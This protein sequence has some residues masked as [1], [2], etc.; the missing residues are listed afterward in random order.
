MKFATSFSI[1]LAL[2]GSIADGVAAQ[3]AQPPGAAAL[4]PSAVAES[5]VVL[6]MLDSLVLA[7]PK[8][9][10]AWHRLGM[11]AWALATRDKANSDIKQ[12]D[13]T[14]LDRMAD[15][16]LR[17]A[18]SLA[19]DSARYAL[20][21]SQFL[22][23]SGHAAAR[24]A[25][26]LMALD[27][28]A[29]GRASTNPGEHAASAM[30][31]G[32]VRWLRYESLAH[33]RVET[34]QGPAPRSIFLGSTPFT[35]LYPKLAELVR[36]ELFNET[37]GR[38]MSDPNGASPAALDYQ[39]LKAQSELGPPVFALKEIIETLHATTVPL[40]P[41]LGQEDF[42]AAEML[43]R[44]AY[45][46]APAH[47]AAFRHLAMAL[48]E[49]ERWRETA[50]LARQHIAQLPWDPWGWLALG[51][52]S[53]RLSDDAT[54]AAAFD[55]ALASMT[56][57]ERA[58]IDRVDRILSRS[59]SA[60]IS[61]LQSDDRTAI[62]RRFWLTQNRL[63]SVEHTA[64]R[65]EY[66]A[67]VAYAEI[68]WTIED[69]GVKGADTDRGFVLIRYGPPS[70]I[71]GL[72]PSPGQD[73]TVDVTHF[74]WYEPSGLLFA[75]SGKP[76]YGTMQFPVGDLPYTSAMT[77]AAPVRWDN[78]G[79]MTI[80]SLPVRTA[81]FRAGTGSVD[82]V[83]SSRA[84]V[85]SI[86]SSMTVQ[87]PVRVN[88]WM[89][90]R[91][92][93][94]VVR[95]SMLANAGTATNFVHRVQAG[96]YLLRAEAS[97]QSANLAASTTLRVR[98]DNDSATGF[99]E[100]GFG[101]S[102]VL[103]G[104]SLVAPARA[105]RSWRDVDLTPVAGPL[106]RH[107]PLSLVWES[108]DFGARDGN[109]QYSIEVVLEREA[110]QGGRIVADVLNTLGNLIGVQRAGDRVTFQFNRELSSAR[111]IVEAMQID[112]RQTPLGKYKL[113]VRETDLVT[114]R[115]TFRTTTVEIRD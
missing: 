115:A 105:P 93:A 88:L 10:A 70:E 57:A 75:F 44:E 83:V 43:F 1:S 36:E 81:R 94:I 34:P 113:T 78:I 19:K 84:P 90:D 87:G 101:M 11:V 26:G 65:V 100:R 71:I 13:H 85:D 102:D 66:L 21:V 112:V 40:T 103:L 68:R 110:G 31:A 12:L 58:R 104:S 54:A 35:R 106:S 20:A 73:V 14:R 8:D 22:Q 28:N 89:L 62:T 50:T 67:R 55:S 27:A 16:S 2:A 97:A 37:G 82:V 7:H 32:Q 30:A 59:D 23:S 86:R 114:G 46:A 6:R 47:A 109:M 64:P 95:D 49:N 52:A 42:K 96:T 51:L 29:I 107:D 72:A 61:A 53:H 33:R 17:I 108:Y 60:R 3:N 69:A 91:R 56:P 111:T 41:G 9:A 77:D 74:W 79:G 4:S 45:E 92:D 38:G 98:A 39:F 80:D 18:A 99:A 48:V 76:T 15:T 25:G 63:W 24:F 5:L